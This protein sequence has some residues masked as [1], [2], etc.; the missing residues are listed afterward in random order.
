MA[1]KKVSCGS[2]AAGNRGQ[3]DGQTNNPTAGFGGDWNFAEAQAF[4]SSF[5]SPTSRIPPYLGLSNQPR[6][7]LSDNSAQS[8]N[9]TNPTS[10]AGFLAQASFAMQTPPRQ[11]AMDVGQH[12]QTPLADQSSS[13]ASSTPTGSA[14]SRSPSSQDPLQFFHPLTGRPTR[15]L[16]DHEKHLLDEFY[17]AKYPFASKPTP[18]EIE[19]WRLRLP[20]YEMEEWNYFVLARQTEEQAKARLQSVEEH[21]TVINGILEAERKKQ[22]RN[23]PLRR[24][25]GK[26]R[27]SAKEVVRK[28][29]HL[30]MFLSSSQLLVCQH[31][32]TVI[33]KKESTEDDGDQDVDEDKKV[34]KGDSDVEPD[35]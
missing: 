29:H 14:A 13:A 34:K 23:D 35:S 27:K 5:A 11:Q 30:L 22:L 31:L 15:K 16:L 18:R 28:H 20:D 2:Y 21:N 12:L 33:A 24:T 17:I 7:N 8:L 19:E 3:A 4:A 10:Q 9:F 26:E 32:L 25:V 1:G 6:V